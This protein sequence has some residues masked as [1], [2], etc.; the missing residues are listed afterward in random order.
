MYKELFDDEEEERQEPEERIKAGGVPPK[1]FL[2]DSAGN[3]INEET[4]E[5]MDG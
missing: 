3:L 2:K 4:G 5:V 1:G